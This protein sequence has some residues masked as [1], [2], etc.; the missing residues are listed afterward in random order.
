MSTR[1]SGALICR[2]SWLKNRAPPSAARSWRAASRSRAPGRLRHPGRPRGQRRAPPAPAAASSTRKSGS[3]EPRSAA[4]GPP[5]STTPAAPPMRSSP[6]APRRSSVSSSSSSAPSSTTE[7]RPPPTT[8]LVPNPGS[9]SHGLLYY[10]GT[11]GERIMPALDVPAERI[12][13]TNGAGDI[14][15]GAYVYSYL[16]S[17]SSTWE[18]HFRFAR[19]ASAHAIQHLGNEASLPSLAQINEAHA[20]FDERREELDLMLTR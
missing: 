20:R 16:T 15:D 7:R 19:A 8:P 4:T 5:P 17:P 9:T 11:E 18:A 14:F 13:D 12:I 3:G 1:R 6:S 2:I 10:Q